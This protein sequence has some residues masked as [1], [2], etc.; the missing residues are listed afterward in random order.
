MSSDKDGIR[1][2]VEAAAETMKGLVPTA[3]STTDL[4]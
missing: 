1:M 2:R 4:G 3:N